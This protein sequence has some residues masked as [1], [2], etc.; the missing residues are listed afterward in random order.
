MIQ[1]WQ[2][3][4]NWEQGVNFHVRDVR[5]RVLTDFAWVT[6]KAYVDVDTG[7]F[8]MTHLFEFIDGRWYMVEH[9]C[10][11]MDPGMEQPVAHG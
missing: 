10:T 3:A 9:H 11:V 5:A 8:N 2:R 7:P 1:S 4:F 6:M